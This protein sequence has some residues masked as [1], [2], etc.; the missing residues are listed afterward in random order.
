MTQRLL[1]LRPAESAGEKAQ[2]V[3]ESLALVGAMIP[4]DRV[5]V[6][7]Y[8]L[9]AYVKAGMPGAGTVMEIALLVEPFWLE[10]VI[11]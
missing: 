9:P 7:E 11:V 8:G 6:K 4:A 5:A 1:K 3:T 2:E 10:A